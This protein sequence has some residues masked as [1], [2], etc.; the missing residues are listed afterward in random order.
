[1]K[2][3]DIFTIFTSP[4]KHL[5]YPQESCISKLSSISLMMTAYSRTGKIEN[6]SHANFKD[7]VKIMVNKS[8]EWCFRESVKIKMLSGFLYMK[9]RQELK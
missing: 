9:Q 2:L 4:V 7:D 6:Y 5:V 1:M 3:L 8:S